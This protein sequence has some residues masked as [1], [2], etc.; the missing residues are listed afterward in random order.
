MNASTFAKS[1]LPPPVRERLRPLYRRL[2]SMSWPYYCSVCEK[3]V[4]QFVPLPAFYEDELRKHGSDLRIE[5]GETCNR[6]AYS[7]PLCGAADRDRL[8]ALYLAKRI[9]PLGPSGF[10][11]L[12]IAP[13]KPLSAHIRRKYPIAYRTADLFM[14]GVDDRVDV[15]R[16]DSYADGSFDA[17]ICSHVLEHIPDDRK[18]M[19]ELY[20]VLKPGG[21]GIA[22][23]PISL[24]LK[25]IREDPTA[26][27]VAERWRLFGQ[28][29]HVRVYTRDGFLARLREAGF[30]VLELGE[31][32]FGKGTLSRCGITEISRL[33]VVEK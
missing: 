29:D 5:D 6:N 33:Y 17:F 18:A 28:D 12:D 20:R 32:F 22:M 23:V 2:R 31:D 15:T 13:A 26:Q 14:E 7:C 30:R 4:Q 10:R 3:K 1:L 21:W 24:K 19:S 27:S 9:E 11:L 8:Y 16:M 25:Q